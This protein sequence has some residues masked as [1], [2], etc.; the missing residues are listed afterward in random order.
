LEILADEC[1][2]AR[3]DNCRLDEDDLLYLQRAASLARSGQLVMEGFFGEVVA[4]V[5][6]EALQTE[7]KKLIVAKFKQAV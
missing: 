5:P 1:S 2:L 6:V 4:Q 7:L 3:C